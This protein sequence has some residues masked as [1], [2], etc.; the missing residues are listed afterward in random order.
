LLAFLLA[1]TVGSWLYST[2]YGQPPRAT[3]ASAQTVKVSAGADDAYDYSATEF[4]N[5]TSTMRVG[6]NSGKKATMGFRF[7]G[8]NVPAGA[9]ITGAILRVKSYQA[10]SN[11]LH[12]KVSA[13]AADNAGSFA[14]ASV[15]PSARVKTVRQVDWDPGAWS[16]GVWYEGPDLKDVV[17]EVVNRSGWAGGNALV[18]LLA[19]DGSATSVNRLVYAY[20]SGSANGVELQIQYTIVPVATSTPT[21]TP[22]ATSTPSPT[23]TA[24]VTP[25]PTVTHMPTPTST[26]TPTATSTPTPTVTYTPTPTPTATST[27][28]G[29]PSEFELEVWRLVNQQRT[30]NGLPSL[31]WASELWCAAHGHSVDMATND[32]FSHYG[33]LDNSAF[34]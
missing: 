17:Q 7:S 12:L 6:D 31:A 9:T 5:N 14:D 4:W 26:P 2:A 27:P 33:C 19:D 24:T 8:V 18:L 28:S 29:G 32:C 22:T 11:A 30:T 1:M 21:A 10:W 34:W 20:N 23:A 15:R 16:S 3:A 25:T 13:E